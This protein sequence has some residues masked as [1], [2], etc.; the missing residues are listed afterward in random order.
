MEHKKVYHPKWRYHKTR[1]AQLVKSEAHEKALGEG[2]EDS[3]EKH[4]VVTHPH[5]DEFLAMKESEEFECEEAE[6]GEEH[7]VPAEKPKK[8]KKPKAP[9]QSE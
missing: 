4:G 8:P 6:E 7:E 5:S 9:K 3:P 1:P 2:W